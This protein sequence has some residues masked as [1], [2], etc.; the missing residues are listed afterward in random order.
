M[1]GNTMAMRAL[2]SAFVLV[3]AGLHGPQALAQNAEIDTIHLV[4]RDKTHLVSTAAFNG[5]DPEA[6]ILGRWRIPRSHVRFLC[7]GTCPV[8]LPTE[9]VAQDTVVWKSGE[10][11]TGPVMVTGE[12]ERGAASELGLQEGSGRSMREAAYIQFAEPEAA[13]TVTGSKEASQPAE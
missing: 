8:K 11:T 6:I 1:E 5:I 4:K 10:R 9:P 13:A 3:L 7:F 2:A 12:F